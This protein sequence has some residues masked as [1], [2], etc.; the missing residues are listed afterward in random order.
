MF[1]SPSPEILSTSQIT[2]ESRNMYR[3][4][5]TPSEFSFSTSPTIHFSFVP[6]PTKSAATSNMSNDE[7]VFD[8]VSNEFFSHDSDEIESKPLALLLPG[9]DGVGISSSTQYEDLS[10][11]FEFWRMS[12][13]I[14][15]DRTSFNDLVTMVVRFLDEATKRNNKE[16]LLIGESFGGLL[17]PNVALRL[18]NR[19]KRREKNNVEENLH[20]KGLV[21]VNPATS[22]DETQWGSFAPALSSLRHLETQN[23][24][25]TNTFPTPYSVLGGAAL[26]TTIPD[27]EQFQQILDIILSEYSGRVPDLEMATE[28]LASMKE[29]FDVLAENLPAATLEHRITR[30]MPVGTSVINSRLSEIDVPSVV[31]AGSEDK[32]LPSKKEALRL[33]KEMPNCERVDI[34][35]SGHFVLDNRVNLTDIILNSH[36]FPVEESDVKIDPILDWEAPT[37]EEIHQ[38]LVDRVEPIRKFTSPVFFSTDKSGKRRKGLSHIPGSDEGPILFVANHQLCKYILEL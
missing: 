28:G 20:L 36:I 27:S 34:A 14:S 19:S 29:G 35:G 24:E 4:L 10:S 22:Y 15:E 12:I 26:A 18:R 17:A 3:Q 2:E 13:D 38:I 32:M 25:D 31:V 30:W 8:S 11:N 23:K 1:S 16:V 33:E 5:S 9:L 7:S 21:M 37:K 6:P